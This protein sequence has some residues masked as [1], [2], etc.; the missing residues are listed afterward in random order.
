M[1]AFSQSF[2][3]GNFWGQI[4][5]T[6][7]VLQVELSQPTLQAKL[8]DRGLTPNTMKCVTDQMTISNSS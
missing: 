5:L 8:L 3:L 7:L 1:W 6:V 4:L 2:A